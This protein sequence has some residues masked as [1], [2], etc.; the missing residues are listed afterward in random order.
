[1]SKVIDITKYEHLR[2]KSPKSIHDFEE[3]AVCCIKWT[4]DKTGVE[5]WIS[6]DFLRSKLGRHVV[7]EGM[8]AVIEDILKSDTDTVALDL[9]AA[10]RQVILER[11]GEL[12]E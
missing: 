8:L 10:F 3:A 2:P 11:Y 7:C 5:Y 9:A 1:M 4:E 6:G 12:E